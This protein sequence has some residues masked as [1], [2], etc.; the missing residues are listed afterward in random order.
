MRDAKTM[1]GIDVSHWQGLIDWKKVKASGIQFAI[2]K[3]GGSD[4]GFYKDK[5]F[6]R[7]Y[8]KAKENGVFVGAYYFVG[9]HCTSFI[10]GVADAERFMKLLDGK[11][12]EMP[13]VIDIETTPAWKKQG[14]T[15]AVIWFCKT[16]EA[17]KGYASVYGSDI[18]GFRDRLNLDR[19][20]AFDKWVARYGSKPKYVK[21]YGIWQSTSKG[22]VNGIQGN[23]D[24][25]ESYLDYPAIMARTGLN[26]F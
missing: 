23:V 3:A 16:I 2:I 9:Q 11:S 15:D 6:E 20:T 21:K 13:V 22:V 14:A 24:L 1:R 12:F 17:N 8:E 19:L 10:D 26:K 5:R 7:N 4:A 25:D 18:G